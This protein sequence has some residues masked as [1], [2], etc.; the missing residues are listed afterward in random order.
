ME[1]VVLKTETDD[2]C[3][4]LVASNLTG[5]SHVIIS[6][7]MSL[8]PCHVAVSNCGYVDWRGLAP[9]GREPQTRTNSKWSLHFKQT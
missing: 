2:A 6:V 8:G 1:F 7:S 5:K 4:G 9:A 3:T